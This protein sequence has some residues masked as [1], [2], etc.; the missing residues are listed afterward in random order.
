MRTRCYGNDSRGSLYEDQLKGRD[1]AEYV[2]QRLR[3]NRR[4][5]G[6]C[7]KI[8]HKHEFDEVLATEVVL[9]RRGNKEK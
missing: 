9:R 4:K 2:Q 5:D 1:R 6:E 3:E 8:D 7:E